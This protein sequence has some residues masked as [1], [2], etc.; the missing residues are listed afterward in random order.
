MGKSHQATGEVDLN[1]TVPALPLTPTPTVAQPQTLLFPP[2]PL[3]TTPQPNFLPQHLSHHPLQQISPTP[4]PQ[5]MRSHGEQ[6]TSNQSPPVH[7]EQQ[8]PFRSLEPIVKILL[9][10]KE[11]QL[12]DSSSLRSDLYAS[13]LCGKLFACNSVS[14]I[15]ISSFGSILLLYLLLTT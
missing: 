12:V 1:E 9:A 2:A 14:L 13:H 6:W 7:R 5:A 3:P 10:V 11:V 4:S 8:P 15:P